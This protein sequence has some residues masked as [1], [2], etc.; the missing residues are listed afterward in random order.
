VAA[1]I[2]PRAVFLERGTVRYDGP[3]ADLLDRP[4]LAR[5]VFLSERAAVTPARRPK[6]SAAATTDGTNGNGSRPVTLEI[7]DVRKSFGG[8]AAL[9][10]VSLTAHAGEIVGIIGANG[11]GKTTLLDVAS[12]FLGA[13]NGRICVDG[14]DVTA[15]S[16]ADRAE[17]GLGRVFQDARLFPSLT[18]RETLAV[19]LERH[20]DVRDP[21]ACML[22]L[23]A[24]RASERA[25]ADRVDELLS[26]LTLDQFADT[27]VSELS[28][29]TRRLVELAC[30]LAHQPRVLLL[31]EPTSGVAQREGEA[32]A[33]LLTDLRDR[34]GA[35]LVIVEHDVPL[36]AGVADRLVCLHLGA[37]IADGLPADVLASP[38]VVTAYLGTADAQ[39]GR[40]VRRR[41]AGAGAGGR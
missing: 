21:L 38:E 13:D 37:T 29:G 7:T 23:K 1:S 35:T 27:F 28:T 24:T 33:G 30:V 6:P 5:A 39:P 32:M 12:G 25:V 11:A 22:R 31:D 36:V 8:V 9:H 40:R 19:A 41:R 2:A 18:V 14:V 20:V 15:A 10:D 34:T 16:P 3:T 4:D 26:T 17:L